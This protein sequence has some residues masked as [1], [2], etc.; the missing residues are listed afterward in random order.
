MERNSLQSFP[1]WS[2]AMAAIAESRF[3]LNL[4]RKE[5]VWP[6]GAQVRRTLGVVE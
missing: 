5:G 1:E 3:Q 4:W 2:V 6:L